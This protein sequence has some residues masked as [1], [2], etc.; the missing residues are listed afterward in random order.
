MKKLLGLISLLFILSSCGLFSDHKR[1]INGYW[2][3]KPTDR[4]HA[5][6]KI[7]YPTLTRCSEGYNHNT[8]T[9]FTSV[10]RYKL[11]D[12][13]HHVFMRGHHK[14]MLVSTGDA[15]LRVDMQSGINYWYSPDKQGY[16]NC[17]TR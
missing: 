11:V 1:P 16:K 10:F 3:L 12:T 9:T 17:L 5:W 14:I 2:K 4:L 7:D 8:D 13:G 15:L 6:I